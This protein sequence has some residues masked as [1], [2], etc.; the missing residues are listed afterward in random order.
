MAHVDIEVVKLEFSRIPVFVALFKGKE[1]NTMEGAD[2]EG[3][4]NFVKT[5]I[6][7]N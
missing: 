5:L 2:D 3:L 6:L 1:I 7:T 4:K